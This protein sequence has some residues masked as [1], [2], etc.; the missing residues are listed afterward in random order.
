MGK[1]WK[2]FIFDFDGVLVDS[3]S[4]L[5]SLYNQIASNIRLKS[6]VKE[7]VKRALKYE[8]EQDARGNYNRKSWWPALFDEFQECKDAWDL[9]KLLRIFHEERIEQT[10][11]TGEVMNVLKW[12]RNRGATMIILAGSDG[13]RSVKKRR[14]EKSGVMDFFEEIFILGEDVKTRKEGIKLILKKYNVSESQLIFIDDKPGPI[15]EM[16]MNFEDITTVKVE[17]KG[18][19]KLA[20]EKEKCVPTY[21]IERIAELKRIIETHGTRSSQKVR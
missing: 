6:D 8:D 18:T 16:Q 15:N 9:N 21:R 3:Y 14:I 12:L 7:F 10:K 5:P 11:I 19:L 1:N 20:W 2:V 17:F 13:Q 4:C